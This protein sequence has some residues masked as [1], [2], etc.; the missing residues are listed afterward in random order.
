MVKFKVLK[1][2]KDKH[3][4]DIYVAGCEIELT[5][6]RVKE[7]ITNLGDGFL[8]AIAPEKKVEKPPKKQ[9]KK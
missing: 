5:E 8:V 4:K 2:F 7:V 1:D 6:K 3:T 9:T